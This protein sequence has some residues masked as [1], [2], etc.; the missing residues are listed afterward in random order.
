MP[1][2]HFEEDAPPTRVPRAML[3]AA[4]AMMLLV[5]ALAFTA[6]VTDRGSLRIATGETPLAMRDLRF[7]D[8]ADG[9][10]VITDVQ[11]GQAVHVLEPGVNSF[12]RGALRGLAYERRRDGI[13]PE[14]PFRLA[15][16]PDGRLTLED[17]STGTLLD[18]AAYGFVNQD[19]FAQLLPN[20][21]GGITVNLP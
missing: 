4:A 16:W 20:V 14:P 8:R 21:R 3:L 13:G 19:A 7:A 15:R 11:T 1:Q 17:P 2:I 5:T 6:R 10:V 9:A 18:L 12:I